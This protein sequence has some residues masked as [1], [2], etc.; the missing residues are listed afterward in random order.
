MTK[1]LTKFYEPLQKFRGRIWPCKVHLN[2]PV[3]LI[4]LIVPR[5]YVCGGYMCFYFYLFYVLE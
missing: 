2:P 1:Q 3:N 4:L 5:R